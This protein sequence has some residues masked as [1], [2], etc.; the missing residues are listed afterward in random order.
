MTSIKATIGAWANCAAV[1]LCLAGAAGA[2]DDPAITATVPDEQGYIQLNFPQT[3]DLS[4]LIEYVS[5][6]LEINIIYNEAIGANRISLVSPVRIQEDGLMKLL[7]TALEM[8]DLELVDTDNPRWKII[9]RKA[10]VRFVAVEHISASDL[11]QQIT[12]VL[13]EKNRISS[14]G[15]PAASPTARR[16]VRTPGA[17]MASG[18]GVTL[19]PDDR[20]NQIIVVGTEEAANDA[21]RLVREMDLP[22][23][24]ATKVYRL[25]YITPERLDTLMKSR[26]EAQEP[27]TTYQSTIDEAS[28]LLIVTASPMLHEQIQALQAELDVEADPNRSYVQYYKLINTTADDVLSTIRSLQGQP[29]VG[30]KDEQR[31]PSTHQRFTGVNYPPVPGA[32]VQPPPRIYQRTAE[33]PAAGQP[34]PT[35]ATTQPSVSPAQL[36]AEDVVVTADENTNTIIVIGPPDVQAIYREL[37]SVLDKRRPQV[38]VEV[39]LV[40]LDTTDDF[41]LGVELGFRNDGDNPLIVFSQFGLSVHDAAGIPTLAPATGFN[42]VLLSPG[43][44]DV[45]VQALKGD[46]RARV[47]AAPKILVNDNASGK[48]ASLDERPYT[49]INASET[50]NTTS[51]AGYAEAG[52]TLAVTPHI[53]EGDHLQLQYS[54]TLNS[55]TG[56]GTENSPPPRATDTVDSE[57]TVPNGYA[58]VVGGL[59]RQDRTERNSRIPGVGEIPLIGRYLFGSEVRSDDESTLFVFIRPTILRDDEFEDLKYLSEYELNLAELPSNLPHS[60]PVPMH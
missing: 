58:V 55:F 5:K 42:G 34:A 27:R 3:V 21:V 19:I 46:S 7:R 4:T 24:V 26:V 56:E 25:R 41:R 15:G 45:V 44:L 50:V 18:A 40:S 11:A 28:G 57:V 49:S 12:S 17:Q 36:L 48:L 29:D 54:I 20:T 38:L 59:R 47:L 32:A 23:N 13:A 6:R 16:V 30:S 14:T 2:Q 52:T 53:S 22:A 31:L 8:N 10:V 1:M 43:T 35:A 33:P 51:F 9:G 37:I 39:I 60:E